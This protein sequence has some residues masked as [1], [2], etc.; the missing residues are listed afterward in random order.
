[1]APQP[2][3][4]F[5][6]RLKHSSVLSAVFIT[7]LAGAY[8]GLRAFNAT[9]P[10]VRSRLDQTWFQIWLVLCAIVV[11]TGLLL[12][13][14][15]WSWAAGLWSHRRGRRFEVGLV[16]VSVAAAMAASAWFVVGS[17]LYVST[18]PLER[19]PPTLLLL[20]AFAFLAAALPTTLGSVLTEGALQGL[21]TEQRDSVG[22]YLELKERL[23][24]SLTLCAVAIAMFTL[25]LGAWRRA[26]IVSQFATA[27]TFPAEYVVLGGFYW[28]LFLAV[29]YASLYLALVSTGREI[30]DALCPL[31]EQA[32]AARISERKSLEERLKL[33]SSAADVIRGGLSVLAPLAGS[34]LSLVAGEK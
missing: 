20:M 9:S 1:M 19:G 14:P 15:L 22:R 18:P 26:A 11:M 34:L 7:V 28:S 4:P 33:P 32:D 8:L 27:A 10:E 23:E 2:E 29:D 24:Q 21:R 5:A 17:Q 31:P 13:F 16:A 12:A 30:R 3:R 25:P 6:D